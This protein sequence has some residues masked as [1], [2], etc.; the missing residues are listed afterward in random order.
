VV[1]VSLKKKINIALITLAACVRGTESTDRETAD[2]RVPSA[3]DAGALSGDASARDAE[4]E[5]YVDRYRCENHPQA[6]S[7]I[8][9]AIVDAGCEFPVAKNTTAVSC[10]ADCPIGVGGLQFDDR[11]RCLRGVSFGC[12]K[13]PAETNGPEY[14][15]CFKNVKD[16]RIISTRDTWPFRNANWV[17]CTADEA[18]TVS[19]I[20]WR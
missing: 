2:K 3:S 10:G 9:P 11:Y 5:A 8:A 16:G 12:V 15:V 4:Q 19:A 14:L 1:A 20:M 18:A 13:G 7:D 6:A 17:D